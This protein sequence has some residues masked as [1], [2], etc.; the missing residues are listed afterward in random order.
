M[1]RDDGIKQRSTFNTRMIL[2][3]DA[4]IVVP[5]GGRKTHEKPQSLSMRMYKVNAQ[6]CTLSV[7][8][9]RPSN[10]TCCAGT[11]SHNTQH[12]HRIQMQFAPRYSSSHVHKIKYKCKN[13]E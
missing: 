4:R 1:P 7:S 13:T 11:P 9:L 8:S 10:A 12:T 5:T 3:M 2:R 6:N